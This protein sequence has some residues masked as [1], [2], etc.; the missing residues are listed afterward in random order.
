M[1]SRYDF[2]NNIDNI[3]YNWEWATRS[4]IHTVLERHFVEYVFLWFKTVYVCHSLYLVGRWDV[5]TSAFANLSTA[6]FI[7]KD[8]TTE[9]VIRSGP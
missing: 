1:T 8:R 4:T 7:K 2:K 6:T 5:Q 9:Q 3:T